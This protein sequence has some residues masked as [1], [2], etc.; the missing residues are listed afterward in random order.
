MATGHIIK[1]IIELVETYLTLRKTKIMS[2][3]PGSQKN[4]NLIQQCIILFKLNSLP[5]FISLINK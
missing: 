2:L 4:K 5:L 3:A 1:I